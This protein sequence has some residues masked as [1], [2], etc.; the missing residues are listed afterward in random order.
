MS[1]HTTTTTTTTTSSSSSIHSSGYNDQTIT[2]YEWDKNLVLPQCGVILILSKDNESCLLTGLKAHDDNGDIDNSWFEEPKLSYDELIGTLIKYSTLKQEKEIGLLIPQDSYKSKLQKLMER[3]SDIK[4]T[5]FI[6]FDI[7]SVE[8]KKSK[9]MYQMII[10][11]KRNNLRVIILSSQSIWFRT[12]LITY[13]DLIFENHLQYH[14][15]IL[16]YV[17][18]PDDYS[19]LTRTLR[20]I[21]RRNDCSF[22][23]WT[24]DRNLGYLY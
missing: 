10:D 19:N 8:N 14:D 24:K 7:L 11:A 18:H 20:E 1:D 4:E 9:I 22:M 12:H 6:N 2:K 3:K 5:I 15:S 21:I 13:I 23:I 16:S 17:Y